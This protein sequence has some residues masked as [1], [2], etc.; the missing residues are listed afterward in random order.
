[1]RKAIGGTGAVFD[2]QRTVPVYFRG[3]PEDDWNRTLTFGKL[4]YKSCPSFL[5]T[6]S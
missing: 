6:G 5:R 4:V 3:S 2:F 1:M